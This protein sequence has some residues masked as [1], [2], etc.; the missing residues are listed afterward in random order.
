MTVNPVDTD[1]DGDIDKLEVTIS[2]AYPCIDYYLPI[3]IHN[4]G[5]IPVIIS[6]IKIDRGT[7]PS[8]ATVEILEDKVMILI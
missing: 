4:I 5:S 6:D 1:G 7:L 2:N 8:G 3:D